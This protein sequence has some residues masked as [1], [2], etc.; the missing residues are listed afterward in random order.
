MG[1]ALELG[2]GCG[3]LPAVTGEF[4]PDTAGFSSLQPGRV[5]LYGGLCRAAGFLRKVK[6]EATSREGMMMCLDLNGR[7]SKLVW[8]K[9]NLGSSTLTLNVDLSGDINQVFFSNSVL[10][11]MMP[12]FKG[13]GKWSDKD[14]YLC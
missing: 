5:R 1:E 10:G 4:Q 8:N 14:F 11:L 13:E 3:G 2:G 6:E 12:L 7:R 9:I